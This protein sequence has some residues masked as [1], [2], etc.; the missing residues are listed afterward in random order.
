MFYIELGGWFNF[1]LLVED[2]TERIVLLL[3]HGLLDF[4]L[5][6]EDGSY[7]LIRLVSAR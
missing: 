4:S 6:K 1:G 3:L 7:V 5:F 2:E